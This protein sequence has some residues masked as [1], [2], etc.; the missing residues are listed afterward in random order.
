MEFRIG[1][2]A[3][4]RPRTA[5]SSKSRERGDS[6]PPAKTNWVSR[7]AIAQRVDLTSPCDRHPA[8]CKGAAVVARDINHEPVVVG[9]YLLHRKIAR[10]G[11]ATIHIA[12]LLGDVGFSRIVAAKRMHPEL[13]EDHEFVAM[14]LNEARIASKVHHRN[15]VPV[16]DV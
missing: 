15:V 10:G 14:F 1:S 8:A 11:M 5:R 16:L 2:S 6:A 3:A 9:R 13:V 12:R 7:V 4:K